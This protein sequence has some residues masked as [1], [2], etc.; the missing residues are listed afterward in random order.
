MIRVANGPFNAGLH[1]QAQLELHQ[2][3]QKVT[4]ERFPG[5]NQYKLQVE[6]F[7]HSVR[8]GE[9]YACPLEFV[10]GTQAMI[11]MVFAAAR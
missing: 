5:V 7:R 9:P 8:T 1:D 11:D 10:R 2:P 6:A 3:G 4:I